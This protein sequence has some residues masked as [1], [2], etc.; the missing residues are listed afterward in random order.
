MSQM[1]LFAPREQDVIE[2]VQP[3]AR[4]FRV[5]DEEEKPD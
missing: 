3:F 2:V 1:G 5:K 4:K